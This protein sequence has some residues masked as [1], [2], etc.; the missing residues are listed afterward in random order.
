VIRPWL[1]SA[2]GGSRALLLA[3]EV[4]S[5][6]MAAAWVLAAWNATRSL[7]TPL[8]P[9]MTVIGFALAAIV[10]GWAYHWHRAA[11]AL[12]ISERK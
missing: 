8:L 4:A 12:A 6:A 1:R 5:G 3:W 9:S 7:P 10:A 11:Q 2:A